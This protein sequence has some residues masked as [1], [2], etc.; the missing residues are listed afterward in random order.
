[1]PDTPPTKAHTIPLVH[2]LI[3]TAGFVG[4]IPWASGTFGS[5]VGLGIAFLPGV[6]SPGPLAL[7]ILFFL[8]LGVR[9]SKIVAETVGHQLTKSAT[10]AKEAFQKGGHDVPDPSIV[11]I[12]EVVGMWIALMFVPLNPISAVIAFVAFRFFDIVKPPPARQVER[13]PNGWGIMLDDVVA[14]IYA[15]LSTHTAFFLIALITGN[16]EFHG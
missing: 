5:I 16:P 15:N 6:A 4:Y 3:A 7:L 9:S 10:L 14:G 8:F 11:V 13:I 2:R 12:D 1:V